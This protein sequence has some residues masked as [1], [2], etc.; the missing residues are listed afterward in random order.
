MVSRNLIYSPQ[1]PK[2]VDGTLRDNLIGENKIEQDQ[3]EKY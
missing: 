1:E 3:F 2:F